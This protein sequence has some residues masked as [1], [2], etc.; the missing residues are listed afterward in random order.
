MRIIALLA[1]SACGGAE[2]AAPPPA[3]TPAPSAAPEEYAAVQSYLGHKRAQVFVCYANAVENR[4]IAD[5]AEGQ[6]KLA[7]A[8]LPSGA[9]ENVR[10]AGSTLKAKTVE[11]CVVAMVSRWTLPA[12][13]RRIELTYT[14]EFKPE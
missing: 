10:V 13:S 8:V 14:Y 12:P 1:L 9:A 5:K 4:E 7:L 11:D 2:V 6:V 3:A